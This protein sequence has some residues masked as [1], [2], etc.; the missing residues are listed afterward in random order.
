MVSG[1]IKHFS[2]VVQHYRVTDKS[3]AAF[4]HAYFEAFHPLKYHYLCAFDLKW[5]G[6]ESV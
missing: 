6:S 4:H 2:K 3:R 1:H 5:R